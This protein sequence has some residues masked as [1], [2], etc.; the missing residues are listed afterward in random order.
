[1][2]F[3]GTICASSLLGTVETVISFLSSPIFGQVALLAVAIVV[4]RVLPEGI[5]GQR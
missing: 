1:L 5:S 4:I 2:I 3:L